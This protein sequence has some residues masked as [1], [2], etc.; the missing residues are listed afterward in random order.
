MATNLKPNLTPACI[1]VA[2]VLVSLLHNMPFFT[3]FASTVLHVCVL[4]KH[5]ASALLDSLCVH[6]NQMGLQGAAT[7]F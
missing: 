2:L 7:L 6:T 5:V 3:A 4:T 1:A